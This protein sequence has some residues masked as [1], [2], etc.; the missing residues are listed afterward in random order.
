MLNK[1]KNVEAEQQKNGIGHGGLY[2]Y[3]PHVYRMLPFDFGLF[4]Y[5]EF[6]VA[7]RQRS[8]RMS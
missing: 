8:L 4:C 5:L 7:F 2:V 6:I 3:I 1:G